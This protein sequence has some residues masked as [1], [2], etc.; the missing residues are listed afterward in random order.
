MRGIIIRPLTSQII[1]KF[2]H[3]RINVYIIW[4]IIRLFIIFSTNLMLL[5]IFKFKKFNTNNNCIVFI[6]DVFNMIFRLKYD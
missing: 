5:N 4:D 3:K 6:F 1:S 2:K